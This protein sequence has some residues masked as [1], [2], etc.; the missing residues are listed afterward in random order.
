MKKTI[1]IVLTALILG[2][3]GTLSQKQVT[4]YHT[5]LRKGERHMSASRYE[6]AVEEFIK[7]F[8]IG[9]KIKNS[10]IAEVMLVETYV[11]NGDF[12]KAE[13][14]AEDIIR[15]YPKESDGLHQADGRYLRFTGD[16][17]DH[18]EQG[19]YIIDAYE[20]GIFDCVFR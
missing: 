9:K 2:G 12:T 20:L 11:Q 18:H 10:K 17:P 5:H 4:A 13:E 16:R 3:C 7:A 1:I 6:K 14:S 8:E 15:K 19:V